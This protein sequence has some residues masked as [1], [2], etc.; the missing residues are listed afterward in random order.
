L[1]RDPISKNSLGPK[2]GHYLGT[3]LGHY[4][5]TKLVLI[6]LYIMQTAFYNMFLA[7]ILAIF[8]H[9][10][11]ILA[12]MAF[13]IPSI[14]PKTFLL[15]WVDITIKLFGRKLGHYFAQML[16]K[17]LIKV[18]SIL[19]SFMPKSFIVQDPGCITPS[20]MT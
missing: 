12:V 4:L 20:G 17:H 11:L 5:G 8:V 19:V 1:N 2:L 9:T 14:M 16:T 6:F 7:V 18:I 3:K 10:F 15:D 13:I